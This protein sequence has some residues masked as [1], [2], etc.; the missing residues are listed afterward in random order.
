[1]T[2]TTK[3]PA[4]PKAPVFRTLAA[5]IKAYDSG[6]EG[7]ASVRVAAHAEAKASKDAIVAGKAPKATHAIDCLEA[8][9]NEAKAK[10]NGAPTG[11]RVNITDENMILLSSHAMALGVRSHSALTL[12]LRHQ[13]GIQSNAGRVRRGWAGAYGKG[14]RPT[15]APSLTGDA[16]RDATRAAAHAIVA[17]KAPKAVAK[18]KAPKAPKGK[19][20]TATPKAPAVKAP[21]KGK[22]KPRNAATRVAPKPS[23]QDAA[24]IA[25]AN[26]AA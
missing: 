8:K 26:A 15:E 2:A 7:R 16:L 23:V 21:A 25:A 11:P 17:G 6:V 20:P 19:A 4:P 3:P 22:G 14:S 10:G 1:M 13:P 5:A 12:M 9:R 24:R 18:G